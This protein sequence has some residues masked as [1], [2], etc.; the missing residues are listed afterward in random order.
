MK[1]NRE[2]PENFLAIISDR[3]V[4]EATEDV[5]IVYLMMEEMAKFNSRMAE[6]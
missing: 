6:E 4:A 2:P 5:L 3:R 1:Q